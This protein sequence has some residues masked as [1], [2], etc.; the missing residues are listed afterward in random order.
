MERIGIVLAIVFAVAIMLT[1]TFSGVATAGEPVPGAEIYIEQ[2]ETK[3]TP[4]LERGHDVA[5]NSIRNMKAIIWIEDVV[6]SFLEK[7]KTVVGNL[8][9]SGINHYGINEEGIKLFGQQENNTDLLDLN[10]DSKVDM[11]DYEIYKSMDTIGKAQLIDS[12][13]KESK[14]V[15][16]KLGSDSGSVNHYGIGVGKEEGIK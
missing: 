3:E 13:A 7:V 12:I 16:S 15:K 5:M 4:M 8:V 11:L 9:A 2:E 1:P 14:T 6:D 10:N